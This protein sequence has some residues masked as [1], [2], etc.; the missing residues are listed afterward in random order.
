MARVARNAEYTKEYNRKLILRMLRNQPIS[1][2]E[3]AR[4]TGLTRSSISL[5]VADLINEGV[6][7]E[8]E[9]IES[10][11]GR[12]PLPLAVCGTAGYAI[13]VYL[14]RDG[15]TAGIVDMEGKVHVRR[16]IRIDD[17]A[18]KCAPLLR[19]IEKMRREVGFPDDKYCGIGISAPGPLDGE[20]GRILNPP[21]FALWQ[22]TDIG[23]VLSEG[24]GLPV[25]LENNATCLAG[26]HYGKPE[27][28]GSDQFLLL[29]VDSGVGS[30]V[31]SKGKV[32]KGAGYFTSE[33]GHTTINYRG[34]RCECGNIGCLEC[35]AAIP[36]LLEGSRFRTWRELINACSKSDE[37]KELLY[38]EAEYLSAGVVNLVNLVAVDTVLLAGDLLYGADK[39]APL[40][41]TRINDCIMHGS[42][43]VLPSAR[44][45]D[46]QIL[47][48]A[49]TAFRRTLVV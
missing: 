45:P 35:Y 5:I 49:D 42:V 39:I 12:T 36:R 37:A 34:R 13:G 10:R 43:R 16:R 30:G 41:E 20:S 32:L 21:R 3:L 19:A 8:L 33:L 7:R 38:R 6:V 4:R 48:A 11:Q 23:S 18:D 31:V 14:N 1:R 9:G 29:L 46:I 27:S 26:Y 15:C 17:G 24:T 25:F 2:S 44:T 28:R 40:M 22:Q 47:A